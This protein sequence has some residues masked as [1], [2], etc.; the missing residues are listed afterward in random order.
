MNTELKKSRMIA[1]VAMMAMEGATDLDHR[2]R[3]LVNVTCTIHKEC[4]TY[5]PL[6]E[7]ERLR[8][9]VCTI[10]ALLHIFLG[11]YGVEP[12][13]TVLQKAQAFLGDTL[14]IDRTILKALK[15]AGCTVKEVSGNEDLCS[16]TVASESEDERCD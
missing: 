6:K 10:I 7:P 8:S 3:I 15:D 4:R 12:L 2:I 14:K 11:K 5:D 9:G 13:M 16:A 1:N